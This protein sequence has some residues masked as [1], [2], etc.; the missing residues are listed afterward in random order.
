MVEELITNVNWLAVIVGAFAAYALGAFWY[1]PKLFGKKWMEGVGLIEDG[2]GMSVRAMIE[3]GI[4]TFL[5][6]W[7]I[8]I[9]ETTNSIYTAILIAFTISIL[10][11]ANGLFAKK[12]NAA[13][14]IEGTYILA[15]VVVMVGAQAIF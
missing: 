6:A 10:I 15:M 7:V 14:V 11:V 9:T 3:Q 2:S 8:G 1:S 5:L 4:G 13:I 12:G